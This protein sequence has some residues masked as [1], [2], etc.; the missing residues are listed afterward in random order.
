MLELSEN[1]KVFILSNPLL[2]IRNDRA[3]FLNGDGKWHKLSELLCKVVIGPDEATRK[4]ISRVALSATS[5][6]AALSSWRKKKSFLIKSRIWNS[7]EQFPC[8]SS[9]F[10]CVHSEGSWGSL[11]WMGIKRSGW[12]PQRKTNNKIKNQITHNVVLVRA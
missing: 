10:K 4:S 11:H 5:V 9:A 12:Y 7:G 6:A 2:S 8:D 3:F 1:Y